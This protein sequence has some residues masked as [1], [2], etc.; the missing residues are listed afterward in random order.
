M[1]AR[2]LCISIE[3]VQSP[4]CDRRERKHHPHFEGCKEKR[5]IQQGVMGK[6][7]DLQSDKESRDG[8]T[9][10][11]K[12]SFIIFFSWNL[13][14][15]QWISFTVEISNTGTLTWA[16]SKYTPFENVCYIKHGLHEYPSIS[17]VNAWS[18][19]FPIE[20]WSYLLIYG[21]PQS[22]NLDHLER[23]LCSA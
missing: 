4:L 13:P 9:A 18:L 23:I 14:N 22:C 19:C 10:L 20:D 12:K 2:V 15:A 5:G 11:F 8:Q 21:R 1:R 6:I 3:K 7:I 17:T 16:L